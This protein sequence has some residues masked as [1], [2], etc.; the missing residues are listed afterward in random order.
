M[1]TSLA[2]EFS[3]PLHAAGM[4]IARRSRLGK[5]DRLADSSPWNWSASM[6]GLTG[7]PDRAGGRAGESFLPFSAPGVIGGAVIQAARRSAGLTRRRLARMLTVRSRTVRRWENGTC[8]LFSVR[9]DELCRLATA[10]DQ[11][12]AT[13]GSDAV[14]LVLA[15]RCDLL[16]TGMLR[17]SE[18]YAEVP[19]IDEDSDE[20]EAARSLLR[21]A[22]TGD[23]PE[24]YRPCPPTGPLLT[25]PDRVAFTSVARH[26]IAG[27]HGD[28]LAHYGAALAAVAKG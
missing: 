24:R 1:T 17:G 21:W 15:S 4:T 18:D 11:A 16:V 5:P 28:Q 9:Y 20:G 23:V 3:H 6:A 2:A 14:E 22:L 10:L 25:V 26:L 8:P 19:P 7:S 12:G 13:V 27:S